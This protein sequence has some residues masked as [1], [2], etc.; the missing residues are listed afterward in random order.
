M[1]RPEIV[2]QA[3]ARAVARLQPSHQMT[4]AAVTRYRM[5]LE[6]LNTEL[7]RLTNAVAGGGELA[8]WWPPSGRAR[9][10]GPSFRLNWRS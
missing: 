7:A 4:E 9:R 3:V 8:T 1:L 2:E 5:E 10:G 6:G